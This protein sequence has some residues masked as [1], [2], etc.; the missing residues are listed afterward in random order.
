M[1]LP[2]T[3]QF[4]QH[5]FEL[6]EGMCDILLIRHG[7][8]MPY[9]EG[10]PHPQKEGQSDPPLHPM[11]HKQAEAVGERLKD[12]HFDALYITPLTRTHQTAAPLAKAL[13]MTPIVE[14]D[15]REIYLGDWDDGTFRIK[16]AERD[17]LYL[18]AL[19]EQEWGL[20]PGAET[21]AQLQE[22]VKAGL[23]R[24]AAKHPNQ[25]VGVFVHGGVIGAAFAVATGSTA[26][27]FIGAENGSISRMA[28]NQERMIAR[29]FNE[30]S[31]LEH[32]VDDDA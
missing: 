31:H 21:T 22:R 5:K 12:T 30:V 1:T 20:V 6:P 14:K 26:F 17:P 32:L 10:V 24:I 13:G 16:M 15:L 23:L 19:A 25:R 4:R 29:G 3:R 2:M 28:V 7:E 18:R 27:A 9:V 8:S 11:G